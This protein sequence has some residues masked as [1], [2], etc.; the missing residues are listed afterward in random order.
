VIAIDRDRGENAELTYSMTS[1]NVGNVFSIDPELGLIRVA[2]E[3]DLGSAS[4]Y[5]L[6]VK[7]T[8]H[9]SPA[10]A[11][12]IPVHVMVTMADNAPPRFMRNGAEL[13][14]EIYENE[15]PGS[16]V[17]HIEA[18]S[19]SSLQFEIVAGN[20]GDVF[21]VNPSTG[22]ISTQ[23]RIDYEKLKFYNLTI[24][25]TSMAGASAYCNVIVHVLDRND[26]APRFIQA[27][28]AGQVIRA[29]RP[30]PLH[31]HHHHH[32]Y[33]YYYRYLFPFYELFFFYLH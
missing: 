18:R 26:N 16:F 12:S 15:E 11:N 14:A 3:L 32:Y 31:H 8:D 17:K 25:A 5:I 13:A 24:A 2:R 4:E 20:P 33:Y 27:V 23:E 29:L 28:Y 9:G 1:G 6:L 22:V 10:L 21:F 30:P 7:A 19:T